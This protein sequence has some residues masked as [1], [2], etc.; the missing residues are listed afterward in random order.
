M[1]LAKERFNLRGR[2]LHTLDATFVPFSAQSRMSGVNLGDRQ[3]RK[4]AVDAIRK[5]IEAFG[6]P[7]PPEINHYR[8]EV[9]SMV[10]RLKAGLFKLKLI[11][12]K[13]YSSLIL[14]AS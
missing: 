4:G 5:H 1:V 10:G 8:L 12:A 3:I 14:L 9:G 11:Q 2:E 6:Q 7:F 13:A